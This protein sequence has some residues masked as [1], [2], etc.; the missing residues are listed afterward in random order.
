[1]QQ[2]RVSI[3]LIFENEGINPVRDNVQLTEYLH[4]QTPTC[5]QRDKGVANPFTAI[6]KVRSDRDG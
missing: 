4:K 5:T 3:F 6:C 2:T 1:M